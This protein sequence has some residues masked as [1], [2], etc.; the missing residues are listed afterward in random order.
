M[1][2]TKTQISFADELMEVIAA[3]VESMD[4]TFDDYTA[5]LTD[6]KI[7]EL[8]NRIM[9]QFAGIHKKGAEYMRCM[10]IARARR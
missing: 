7:A 4:M 1:E 2:P 5:K 3:V 6:E 8:H 9:P 10:L